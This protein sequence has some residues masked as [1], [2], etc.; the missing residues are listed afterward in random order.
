MAATELQLPVIQNWSCHNCGGCCREHLIEI[1]EEEKRRIESRSW[2]TDDGVPDDRPLI[3]PHGRRTFR[4]SHR[5]D[6]ACV[7]LDEQG[8]CRIHARFGEAEKPLACRVY[9]YAFHPDGKKITVSLRFSCPSVVQ[10]IGSPLT[11]QK[12]EL[13]RL[14]REVTAG[15]RRDFEPPA[16]HSDQHVDWAD[17][18]RMIRALRESLR[19]SSVD[20]VVRLM[21]TLAWMELVENSRFSEVRGPRL[22]EYLDLITTAARR[23]QPDNDLPLLKPGRTGRTMFRQ[24]VAQF[25][26]H[27]TAAVAR[28]GWKGRWKLLRHGWR[29]TRGTGAVPEITWPHSVQTVFPTHSPEA[30]AVTF[31]SLEGE[32][33]G[34]R[35]E[36]DELFAR[37]FDVKLAGLHFAGAAHGNFDIVTGFYGLA[38][39]YPIVMWLARYRA[40]SEGRSELSFED[41]CAALATADHNYGYSELLTGS[42][43]ARRIRSLARMKQVTALTGWYAR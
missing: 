34:R 30:S 9:P 15:S 37:Y 27:D 10:N 29:F 40:A 41:A 4:L 35:P 38:L 16:I 25:A 23:A 20:F 33:G 21:R 19:D 2:T 17:C 32:F 26:R 8:L 39:M 43:A 31:E 14:A 18:R 3:V 11:E 6:G 42:A 1:T 24:L 28:S 22:D 5:D 12:S 36:K 13:T 7:F